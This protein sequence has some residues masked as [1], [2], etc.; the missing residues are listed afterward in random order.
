LLSDEIL[1]Q[2]AIVAGDFHDETLAIEAE[3]LGHFVAVLFAVLQPGIGIGRKIGV[4]G[5]DIFG[6]LVLFELNEEAFL[7]RVHVKG[8]VDFTV[9]KIG[10]GRVGLTKGRHTEINKRAPQGRAAETARL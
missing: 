4:V 5:E 6:L 1:E 3:T 7:A 9:L 10:S 2:V 8:I